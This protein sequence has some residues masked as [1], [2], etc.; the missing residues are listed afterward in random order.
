MS[1]AEI[2]R[3]V[4]ANSKLVADAEIAKVKEYDLNNE[5]LVSYLNRF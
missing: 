2:D 1:K 3:L 4:A 5:L